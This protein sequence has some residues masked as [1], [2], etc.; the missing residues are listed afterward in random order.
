[1][2][3][4]FLR[5]LT[6]VGVI[7]AG[8]VVAATMAVGGA[9]PVSSDGDTP[10]LAGGQQPLPLVESDEQRLESDYAFT[11]KRLAGSTPISLDQAGELRGKA[12]EHA[13]KLRKEKI[14]S[15]PTTFTGGWTQIGPNPIV[16]ATRGSGGF[17]AMSGRIGALAIR[18]SNG[19]F[20][21]GGAQG[22]IWLYNA[23]TG[24]WSPKTNDSETQA[25]GA[26]AI[27]PSDD[28]VI[29]AGTGEGAPRATRTSATA[30]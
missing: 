20:I 8:V 16:Q 15:G 30:S 6:A 22:G 1:M 11:S 26:L 23:A 4:A 18:P 5:W 3:K 10:T 28:S 27:A 21:L 17:V 13:K 25:I 24:T 9:G 19:Q 14:P 7:T 2:P 29:Y 12:A